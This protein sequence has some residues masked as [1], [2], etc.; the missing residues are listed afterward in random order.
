MGA[1]RDDWKTFKTTY[2][3]WLKLRKSD[4]NLGKTLD[5]IEKLFAA[6]NTQMAEYEDKLKK[7]A[8]DILAKGAVHHKKL[9]EVMLAYRQI[10]TASTLANKDAAAKAL[11]T[12]RDKATR[13]SNWSQPASKRLKEAAEK[14]KT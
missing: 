5:E 11:D 1:L 9:L 3:E 12:F 14:L 2:P 6:I 4:L 7:M 8:D 10:I 13:Y